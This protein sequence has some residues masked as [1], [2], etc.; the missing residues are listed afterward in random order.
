VSYAVKELFYSLQGEGAN[1]GRPAVFVRL[2]GC[3]QWSGREGDRHKGGSCAAW[4]DT[5]FVGTDGPGGGV[6]PD[7]IDLA[8]AAVAAWPGPTSRRQ[9]AF[10]VLTGGESA[11]QVDPALVAALWSHHFTVAIETNGTRPLAIRPDWVTVS[12]KA[13]AELAVTAGD[14]LKLVYPQPGAE[15]GRYE[16]LDF[17]RLYLQPMAGPLLAEHTRSAIDY[18]LAHPRWRLSTQLHKAWQLP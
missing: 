6:Y 18:C 11:L 7:A 8:R 13:G 9:P 17:P 15:P 16:G 10:A 14:E 5:D 4:C 12:P 1:V 2:S 3:N